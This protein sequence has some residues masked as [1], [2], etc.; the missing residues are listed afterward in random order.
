MAEKRL[1]K[2]K[3]VL[4]RASMSRSKF[5]EHINPA[6]ANFDPEAPKPLKVGGRSVRFVDDEVSAWIDVLIQRGRDQNDRKAEAA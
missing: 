3:D 4:E 5:Y 2:V 1:V 6:H